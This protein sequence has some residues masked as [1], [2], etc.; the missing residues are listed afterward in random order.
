MKHSLFFLLLFVPSWL[1]AQVGGTIADKKTGAPIPY[2]NI[3]VENQNLG[4]TSNLE[5]KFNFKENILGK[6]LIVTAIGYEN[7]SSIISTNS[8]KIELTPKTYELEE[9]VANPRKKIELVI[10]EFHKLSLFTHRFSCGG[11]PWII[12]KYFEYLTS[13]EPTPYLNKLRMHTICETETAT[14]NLRL[15]YANEKGEPSNDI[16][17]KNLIVTVAKGTRKT[18]VDLSDYHIS[19]PKKGFFVAVEWLVI[20]SNKSEFNHTRKGSNIQSIELRYNPSFRGVE[21][22]NGIWVYN[23][24]KTWDQLKKHLLTPSEIV[25]DLAI[26]LTLTN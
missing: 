25:I 13:Y 17:K 2:A 26:E 18:T 10:D 16:L 8:L 23:N 1:I 6:I 19:F 9:I 14:F 22:R 7:L 3:W 5:G 24:G 4:T 11:T 21:N 20:E 15:M 12:A